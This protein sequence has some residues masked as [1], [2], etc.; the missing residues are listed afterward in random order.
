MGLGKT[1]QMISLVMAAK[2]EKRAQTI[3]E[4]P[5]YLD[6]EECD[7]DSGEWGSLDVRQSK[8]KHFVL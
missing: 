8:L 6:D 1:L 4:N 7:S 3:A 2:N 5:N